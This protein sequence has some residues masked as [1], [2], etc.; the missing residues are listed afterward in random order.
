MNKLQDDL[1]Q[2]LHGFKSVKRTH[3]KQGQ[4]DW[5]YLDPRGASTVAGM[6]E[7]DV[8]GENAPN[9]QLDSILSDN[10]RQNPED[11][12]IWRTRKDDKVRSKHAEREGKIFNKHI[13]PEGGNPGE[14]YNCRCWAEP[15]KPEKSTNKPIKVD[16]SGLDMF[17]LNSNIGTGTQ[18]QYAQNDK[19]KT[20]NDAIYP[21]DDYARRYVH[22]HS[23][24][25]EKL[26]KRIGAQI[27]VQEGSYDFAYLDSRGY[28]TTGHGALIDSFDN[29]KKAHWLY[30]GRPATEA[31]M[32][33]EFKRMQKVRADIIADEEK[34]AKIANR[35]YSNPFQKR[36]ADTYKDDAVLHIT[37]EEEDY[38]MYT[39]LQKD[40]NNL[41][42]Y[43]PEIDQA[44]AAAQ[45]VAFDI[46]YNP[47]IT[48]KTWNK[49]KNYFNNKN[50]GKLAENVNRKG[51]GES[52]NKEMKRKILSIKKW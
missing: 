19:A 37:E 36:T 29:F 50:V 35:P 41:K 18:T 5:Y 40:Y 16:M 26:L 3:K 52:R 2:R 20:Q 44:P 31:E 38:L 14:E 25:E 10:M 51:V 43:L 49:F 24:E 42:K 6:S 27:I 23:A 7:I 28:I 9:P 17:K 21:S 8:A 48:S 34:R 33:T 22:F 4:S 1:Y 30:N 47:G 12:Y 32:Q 11:Y 15:Y 45:D 46:Q 13:P 39:H